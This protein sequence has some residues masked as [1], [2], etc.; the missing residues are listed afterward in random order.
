MNRYYNK[1]EIDTMFKED[2]MPFIKERE[3]GRK[4]IVLRRTAYNDFI[5]GCAKDS[6]ISEQQRLNYSIPK[7]LIK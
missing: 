5:D 3:N 7:E 6:Y 1:K 4:D 2:W